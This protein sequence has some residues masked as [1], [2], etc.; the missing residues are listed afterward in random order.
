MTQDKGPVSKLD[1]PGT[2][3]NSVVMLASKIQK[4]I[5]PPISLSPYFIARRHTN[6]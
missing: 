6:T 2:A 1:E 3:E 5:N 4:A